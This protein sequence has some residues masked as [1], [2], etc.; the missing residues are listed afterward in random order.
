VWLKGVEK[1]DLIVKRLIVPEVV[2]K[3]EVFDIRFAVESTYDTRAD[4][5]VLVD[6]RQVKGGLLK[7]REIKKGENFFIRRISLPDARLHTIR[8]QVTDRLKAER[9]E[10]DAVINNNRYETFVKVLGKS[11]RVLY[12]EGGNPKRRERPEGGGG[13]PEGDIEQRPERFLRDAL[14]KSKIDVD[15]CGPEGIPQKMAEYEQYDAVIIS[16][17]A[18]RCFEANN[19]MEKIRAYV[20]DMGGGLIMIGG[21]NSFALGNYTDTPIEE[22]LPVNCDV[23]EQHY[24]ASMAIAIVIDR[25]GSMS[26]CAGGKTKLQLAAEGAVA[27]V[28]NLKGRDKLGVLWVDTTTMWRPRVREIG[29]SRQQIIRDVRGAAP[30]GGGILVYTGLVEAYLALKGTNTNAKHI[31]LFAD[32]AD[33]EEL[34]GTIKLARQGRQLTPPITLSVIG[35]GSAQSKDAGF[36]KQLAGEGKGRFHLVRNANELPSIFVKDALI[37]TKSY[38]VEKDFQPRVINLDPAL[39]GL[40]RRG[41]ALPLLRGYVCVTGKKSA[42]VSI[43]SPRKTTDPIL[44]RWQYG[45]GRSAAF[46]SD[47]KNR[48]AVHWLDPG[49]DV[50]HKFWGQLVKSIM[51]SPFPS[52]YSSR[53]YFDRQTG[54]IEVDALDEGEYVNYLALKARVILPDGNAVA[55]DLPQ[56]GP[57]V[58]RGEFDAEQVGGYFA[59]IIDEK[60]GRPIGK[61]QRSIPYSPEY[62][63]TRGN[64][65]L[66]R[67]MAAAAG[68]ACHES[69]EDAAN[70]NLFSHD[71]VERKAYH[72]IWQALLLMAMALLIV[73]VAIRRLTLPRLMGERSRAPRGTKGP[74]FDDLLKRKQQRREEEKKAGEVVDLGQFLAPPE[75]VV[76]GVPIDEEPQA[77]AQDGS[78]QS[79]DTLARLLPL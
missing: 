19:V 66:L 64:P 48:W 77:Q 15:V 76:M 69:L 51:R 55:V 14:V 42:S 36:L 37:A 62:M 7:D 61:M 41:G 8:V 25:S 10:T 13:A 68:G 79:D 23:R 57:G 75:R 35:L 59:V 74:V 28:R 18:A 56:Q 50:Y 30:G 26:A 53:M 40:L 4:I 71:D 32:A 31:I 78:Q 43:V 27:T 70:W 6:D 1:E 17:T 29:T 60:S 3:G 52:M 2:V 73:E 63:T 45:L 38:M 58:Y 47:C 5:R 44:A 22:A 34:H 46:T 12:I 16:D 67:S 72:E 39:R 49:S 65:H 24:L 11:S 9:S 33:A 21:E 20:R 54:R